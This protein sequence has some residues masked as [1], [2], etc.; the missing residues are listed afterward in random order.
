MT[1]PTAN[2]AVPRGQPVLIGGAWRQARAPHSHE[3]RNAATLAPLGVAPDCGALDVADALAAARAAQPSWRATPAALRTECLARVGARLRSGADGLARLLT[4]ESGR[5][6]CESFDEVVAA[7]A[8]FGAFAEQDVAAA[9]SKPAGIDGIIGSCELPLLGTAGRVAAALAAG[10]CVVCVPAPE[11]PLTGLL[12]AECY[13]PL[14]A[15]VVNVI[16]GGPELI[17]AVMDWNGLESTACD[18]RG[19][20][21]LIVLPDADLELAVPG[22]AWLALHNAGQTY[23]ARARIY[24]DTTI[25]SV[26]ADRMH[27]YVAFLEVGDPSKPDTDL[28]PLISHVAMRR[29]E[30]QVALALKDGARLKLG[31]RSFSPWGLSGHF[32]Q[33]TIL[34]DVRHG[35]LAARDEILAPVLSIMPV[36]GLDEA[37]ARTRELACVGAEV[38]TR[39]ATLAAQALRSIRLVEPPPGA[40]PTGRPALAHITARQAVWFPYT[41]RARRGG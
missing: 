38:Y 1:D 33:P 4:Q 30:E 27:E 40:P 21:P 24:V 20:V 28:G 3:I 22:A 16:T 2:A 13:E 11:L 19:A 7:A 17:S 39:N 41:S 25:A 31:G 37:L 5:P 32:F 14:P 26:F 9:A 35:S 36:S 29:A 34:F 12:L 6:L 23:S 18:T 10:R 8:C 15:G